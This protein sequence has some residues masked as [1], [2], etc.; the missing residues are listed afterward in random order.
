[1]LVASFMGVLYYLLIFFAR[2]TCLGAWL[3]FAVAGEAGALSPPLDTVPKNLYKSN[4]I[5]LNLLFSSCFREAGFVPLRRVEPEPSS[6]QADT[7]ELTAFAFAM[8]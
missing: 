4:Q 2:K 1:M 3:S 8:V 6:P 5:G 7:V